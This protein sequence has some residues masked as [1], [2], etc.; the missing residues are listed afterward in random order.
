MVLLFVIKSYKMRFLWDKMA[1]VPAR[2]HGSL[3]QSNFANF[4]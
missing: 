4:M 2:C 3:L 1:I